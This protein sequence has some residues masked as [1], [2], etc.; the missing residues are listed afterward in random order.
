VLAIRTTGR[1][2]AAVE[3][4]GGY[5]AACGRRYLPRSTARR[6]GPALDEVLGKMR[7]EAGTSIARHNQEAP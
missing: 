3:L 6:D 4:S 7:G 1:V 2:R 5:R